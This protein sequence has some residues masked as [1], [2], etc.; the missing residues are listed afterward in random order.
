MAV[1]SRTRLIIVVL[2]IVVVV[3][4]SVIAHRV[5]RGEVRTITGTVARID[6]RTRIASIELVHP[7]TGRRLQIDGA[8]PPDCDIRIDGEPARLSDL[9]V[10]EQA[11]VEG[12]IHWNGSISANW[13][14]VIR[15]ADSDPAPPATT[16]PSE[17]P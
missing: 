10:G 5:L 15:A 14:H 11:T 4:G 8:V 9:R 13:V 1:A 3:L 16:Q 2:A 7:K 17:K 12:V 6:L